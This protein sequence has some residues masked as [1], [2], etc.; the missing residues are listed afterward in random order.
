MKTARTAVRA[1]LT[2]AAPHRPCQA[3]PSG[4][5][6]RMADDLFPVDDARAPHELDL[7]RDAMPFGARVG[8]DEFRVFP[9]GEDRLAALL[10]LIEEARATLD[11]T[12]YIFEN[13]KVG[14]RVRDA[15]AAA[16]RRGVEVRLIIDGFGSSD[17]DEAFFADLVEAGGDFCR[18]SARRSVRYLIRNH[19]KIVIADGRR[20]MI[21]GFN[22]AEAY[23]APPAENGWHDLGMTI[24]GPAV[25]PLQ[26]YFDRLHA[27]TQ[28][29]RAQ[30]RTI[31]RL[32][33]EWDPGKGKV[34]LLLGGPTSRLSPWA[35]SVSFD[36]K[37][38]ERLDMIMAYF[39]PAQSLLR[40]IGRI[41][42]KGQ[43]R[44]VMAGKSDNGATIG[45]TR[46][47]Y[48]YLLKR[49]AKIYEF[50]PC[51]L[52][53]KLI[54]LDD[55]VYIGSANFDMRSLYINAEIMLRIDDAAFADRMRAYVA[56]HIAYCEE[57][58]PAVHR[59]RATPLNRI[60]WALSWFLVT[61]VDYTVSRRLNFGL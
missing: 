41:A 44:L 1:P 38:G 11:L 15:L 45:A 36:L 21:G 57:I 35:R 31:R 42:R 56:T 24:E 49:R 43:T 7:F 48:G 9:A 29:P 40:R 22:V 30:W 27:W 4:Y 55:R 59:A 54:V 28:N 37:H 2:R 19:Q 33:R 60:R 51:K 52:H 8:D 12:F 34:G 58:T 3:P 50:L 32:I 47:L 53:T 6:R 61:V 23:F 18:F 46:L 10:T 16:A 17:T 5:R 39:S 25:T 20:A 13:D 14:V 26:H